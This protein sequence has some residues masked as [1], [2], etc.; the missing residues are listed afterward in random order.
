MKL[1]C[2]AIL[3]VAL[4]TTPA[5]AQQTVPPG[6]Q[7]QA[8]TPIQ[9]DTPPPPPNMGSTHAM[10]MGSTMTSHHMMRHH[11]RHRAGHAVCSTKHS[12]HHRMT[13]CVRTKH[14]KHHWKSNHGKVHHTVKKTIK[15][16]TTTKS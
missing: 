12:K 1:L 14:S 3:G 7:Q 9:A 4:M 15:T 6:T 10:R 2:G 11:G 8:V 16:V 13:R 5:L